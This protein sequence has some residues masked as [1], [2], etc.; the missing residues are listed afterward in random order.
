M[1]PHSGHSRRHLQGHK[2]EVLE[3]GRQEQVQPQAKGNA[4]EVRAFVPVLPCNDARLA[5][6]SW[7]VSLTAR[8]QA[9]CTRHRARGAT[10]SLMGV[11][12]ICDGM[13][14]R[15][16]Q[17][18]WWF[19]FVLLLVAAGGFAL[20]RRRTMV[21]ARTASGRLDA[22]CEAGAGAVERRGM[23]VRCVTCRSVHDLV[24]LLMMFRV[25][26]IDIP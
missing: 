1:Q 10:A 22:S 4:Q 17:G 24:Y 16:G 19:V 20:V 3:K 23:G 9:M 14:V 11:A 2:E 5:F 15:E 26:C 18:K 13:W 12:A 25:A 21:N 7:L 6:A 8:T